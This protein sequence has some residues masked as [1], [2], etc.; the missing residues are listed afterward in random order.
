MRS[1]EE[2]TS[3]DRDRIMKDELWQQISGLGRSELSCLAARAALRA[4]IRSAT[5]PQSGG[6]N[7]FLK[8]VSYGGPSSIEI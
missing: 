6:E 5:I 1:S 8:G 2:I 7:R 3:A 4:L